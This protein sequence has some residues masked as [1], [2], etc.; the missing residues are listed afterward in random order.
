MVPRN[1]GA[2]GPEE[3]SQPEGQQESASDEYREHHVALLAEAEQARFPLFGLSSEF[4]GTRELNG[5]GRRGGEHEVV[6]RVTL[7]H[8][9]GTRTRVDVTVTGP[10]RG[11]T[12][13]GTWSMDP[14][15]MIATEL[16]DRTGVRC[17]S[18][19]ELVKATEHVLVVASRTVRSWSTV[20][21]GRSD[22]C[23]TV[24]IGPR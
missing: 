21:D 9:L 15:P 5:L 14:L 6:D 23:A 4:D 11:R 16:L 3:A 24:R 7:S 1:R 20:S 12:K 13:A 18:G 19:G 22:S 2:S 10:L 17:A 8:G